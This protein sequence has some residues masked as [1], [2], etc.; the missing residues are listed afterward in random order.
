MRTL[1][2]KNL[3]FHRLW[4]ISA[5]S[6]HKAKA[7][8]FSSIL[9]LPPPTPLLKKALLRRGRWS[10]FLQLACKK[11]SSVIDLCFHRQCR[12]DVASDVPC[13]R[14]CLNTFWP[15]CYWFYVCYFIRHGLLADDKRRCE[16]GVKASLHYH[17]MRRK[18]TVTGESQ[19]L[20]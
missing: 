4:Q 8:E 3:K 2:R 10:F 6:L 12:I 11:R 5:F 17:K 18:G 14:C 19:R 20:H 13:L 7:H 16:G 9:A 15:Y 1:W